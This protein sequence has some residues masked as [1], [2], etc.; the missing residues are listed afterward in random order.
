MPAGRT[1]LAYGLRSTSHVATETLMGSDDEMLMGESSVDA[2]ISVALQR[3]DEQALLR[4][5]SRRLLSFAAAGG[6][7]VQ[8]PPYACAGRKQLIV[9]SLLIATM[10]NECQLRGSDQLSTMV[11]TDFAATNLNR[12]FDPAALPHRWLPGLPHVLPSP[13]APR[14]GQR[15]EVVHA[16]DGWQGATWLYAAPGSEVWWEGGRCIETT[17]LLAALL[18]WASVEQVAAAIRSTRDRRECR[19]AAAREYWQWHQAFPDQSW[20]AVVRGAAEGTSPFDLFASA[21]GLLFTKL[22]AKAPMGVD[23]IVL[24]NQ[25]HMWPRWGHLEYTYAPLGVAGCL[26]QHSVHAPGSARGSAVAHLATKSKSGTEVKTPGAEVSTAEQRLRVY[27]LTEIMD[28]RPA[29]AVAHAH[30]QSGGTL[31]RV[32]REGVRYEALY[33]S[34]SATRDGLTVCERGPIRSC[35]GCTHRLHVLCACAMANWRV[36]S[37]PVRQHFNFSEVRRCAKRL[38]PGEVSQLAVWAESVRQRDIAWR[39]DLQ[40]H[41]RGRMTEDFVSPTGLSLI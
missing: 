8:V 22:L 18:R 19:S 13:T 27:R 31:R 2:R 30:N 24:V 23:S 12:T 11:R 28:Y 1:P 20:E 41:R 5:S 6:W 37:T 33:R 34:L 3:R 4:Q 40:V 39:H 32:E 21:G 14:C 35:L 29:A 36:W 26:S 15:F 9:Q 7:H 16:H 38:L 17:N 25:P 10:M